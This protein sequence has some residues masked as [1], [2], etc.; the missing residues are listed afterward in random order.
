MPSFL[1]KSKHSAVGWSLQIPKPTSERVPLAFHGTHAPRMAC[2]LRGGPNVPRR[3]RSR[4]PNLATFG[5]GFSPGDQTRPLAR[6]RRSA[7]SSSIFGSSPVHHRCSLPCLR[8]A[9][10]ALA[11][12]AFALSH[13]GLAVWIKREEEKKTRSSETSMPAISVALRLGSG[14][15]CGLGD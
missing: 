9:S 15:Q 10:S 1:R 2:C 7:V 5:S 4:S 14:T 13:V 3:Q 8:T 12:G 6:C 11:P